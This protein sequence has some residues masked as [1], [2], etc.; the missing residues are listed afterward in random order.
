MIFPKFLPLLCLLGV[1]VGTSSSPGKALP[2]RV[3]GMYLAVSSDFADEGWQSG[4]DWQ[5]KLYQYQQ[6]GANVLFFTFINPVSMEVPVSFANLASTRGNGQSGSVP[7][8]TTI[9][10]SV[11]GYAYSTSY[12]PWE[13]LTSQQAAEAMADQVANWPQMYNVDG[14]D[15][16]IE[17]VCLRAKLD[18]HP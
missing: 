6:E 2:E 4:D 15:L 1:V 18:E 8:D 11:G 3:I 9:I 16:D 17:E 10:F 13:W 14:I 12:H 5:P 7:E